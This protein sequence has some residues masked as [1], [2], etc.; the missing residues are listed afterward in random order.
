MPTSTVLV[1]EDDPAVRGLLL[2]A[3]RLVGYTVLAARD[4]QEAL[5]L[6]TAHVGPIHLLVTD[7]DMP[8]LA[9]GELAQA[10]SAQRPDLSVLFIS[11]R[12]APRDLGD[13][14]VGRTAAFLAKPFTLEQLAAAVAELAGP[15]A[16]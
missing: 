15:P 16:V 12:P 2:R 3:L 5:A 13:R 14:V 4:G 7:L 11:G 8:G 10:L 9:G 6:A 1:A